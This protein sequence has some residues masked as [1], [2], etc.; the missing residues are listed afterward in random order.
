M[1]NIDFCLTTK[2]WMLLKLLSVSSQLFTV[3][4]RR[5]LKY[6]YG[7][8]VLFGYVMSHW[9]IDQVIVLTFDWDYTKAW[10]PDLLFKL[11][12]RFALCATTMR[13]GFFYARR[14][15][16][17]IAEMRHGLTTLNSYTF[18][19]YGQKHKVLVLVFLVRTSGTFW[20]QNWADLVIFAVF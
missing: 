14:R 19:V 18:F 6:I 20:D 2:N 12:R 17:T 9:T 3:C 10:F 7:V 5:F 11:P 8:I 15:S 4:V 16:V 13:V 1:N